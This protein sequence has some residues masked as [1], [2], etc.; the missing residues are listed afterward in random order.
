MQVPRAFQPPP[1]VG[2]C[3]VIYAPS[4]AALPLGSG[5]AVYSCCCCAQVRDCC[6][7]Q[8]ICQVWPTPLPFPSMQTA[9]AVRV[10]LRTW[11]FSSLDMLS[12]SLLMHNL[13]SLYSRHYCT[14]DGVSPTDSISWAYPVT[15]FRRC[16]GVTPTMWVVVERIDVG[17]VLLI[18]PVGLDSCWALC[19]RIESASLCADAGSTVDELNAPFARQGSLRPPFSLRTSCAS[20][21]GVRGPKQDQ[22]SEALFLQ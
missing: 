18:I 9:P 15:W 13:S 8:C 2:A 12:V 22:A 5:S 4:F 1:L 19:V 10:L 17:L 6:L 7:V 16:V 21:V 3:I 11:P 14:D 20:P